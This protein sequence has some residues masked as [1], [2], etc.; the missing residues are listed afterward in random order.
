MK[1]IP[2]RPE[3]IAEIVQQWKG[4]MDFHNEL[5]PFHSRR[6]D[7]H[8]SWEIFLRKSMDSELS[9]A[10]VCVDHDNVIA[11]SLAHVKTNPPILKHDN[12][13]FISDFSV[14]P[15]HR[16]KGIGELMLSEIYNWLETQGIKRVELRVE[17][18][19]NIGYSFWRK[20]GFKEHVHTLYLER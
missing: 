20:H 16:R 6:E 19:N 5:N 14:K 15:E 8:K 17:P 11:F 3:H 2:A 9:L 18:K 1:I 12:F 7:A 13:G 10:L 4:F